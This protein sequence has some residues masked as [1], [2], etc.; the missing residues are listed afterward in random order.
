MIDFGA[1]AHCLAMFKR[2]VFASSAVALS[3]V[4]GCGDGA[5][6]ATSG[7]G[8]SAA[9][10]TVSGG[11][12]SG[13]S[14]GSTTT[15][16]STNGGSA[17]GGSSASGSGGVLGGSG[18][19]SASGGVGGANGGTAG[20]GTEGG[21]STAGSAGAGACT[22]KLCEDFE[23]SAPGPGSDFAI[24]VDKKGT[25]VENTTAKAHSGTHSVHVKINAMG[26]VFGYVTETKSLAATGAS[27][28]GRV[29]LWSEVATPDG[30]I[31]N[32]AVDG[33]SA[34]KD[35]Q[36][37][38]LNIIGDHYATNRRSDDAGK[39]S[40]VS[41]VTGKWAC[42]EWHI[43]PNELHVF[44]EGTELPIAET[45]TMPTVSLVRVGFERFTP[46]MAG[47]L[48]IDDVAINDAQIGCGK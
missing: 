34:D 11:S 15:A 19:A 22:Y 18:G 29:F 27:F 47:D 12:D 42:F 2:R 21:V 17:L 45:W 31:V 36:V 1:S 26:G 8:T 41:P 16:G 6:P 38:I 39:G 13:G 5:T 33:K 43:T 32:I 40:N 44:L 3:L 37:R 14:G 10:G 25:V 20:T 9:A 24:D 28:W 30:H 4:V 23:G 46:G 48:W 35:E 7:G